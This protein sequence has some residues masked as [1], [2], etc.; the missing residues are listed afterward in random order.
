MAKITKSEIVT[1]AF[2]R[3]VSTDHI[4]E[5]DIT[6]AESEYVTA[7]IT[8]TLDVNGAFY[9]DYV[10]PVIAFGVAFDTLER[11]ATEI[12]DRGVVAM[13]N[14]G[15]TVVS[16][17]SMDALRNHYSKQLHKLIELM[18]L[19]AQADEMTLTKVI[20]QFGMVQFTGF[21]RVGA[22]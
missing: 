3:N 6:T 17:R 7:Y 5:A 21:N 14:T 1:L 22:I 12:T 9:E 11:I 18:Y 13:L 2:T 10:K 19:K 16:D 4:L 8:D 20:L 15:A